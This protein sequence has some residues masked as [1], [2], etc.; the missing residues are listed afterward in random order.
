MGRLLLRWVLMAVAVVLVGYIEA[1]VGLTFRTDVQDGGSPWPLFAGVALLAFVNATL[2][3]L[4]KILTIPL[5]CLTLGVFS[6]V[7]NALMLML[8]ASQSLG[9]DLGGDGTARFIS[10]FVASLLISAI[11]GVLGGIILKDKDEDE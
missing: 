3:K 11:N 2:G 5:N 4:L 7:I 10:A 1:A 6:L 8:V 9:F